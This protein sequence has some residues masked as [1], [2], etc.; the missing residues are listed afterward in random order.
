[1]Q[2]RIAKDKKKTKRRV[3]APCME[4]C[5]AQVFRQSEGIHV[6]EAR[7]RSFDINSSR[8]RWVGCRPAR[9]GGGKMDKGFNESG[10]AAVVMPGDGERVEKV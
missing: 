6:V 9:R 3:K 2:Q 1:M 7:R 8:V 4:R 10:K 5:A